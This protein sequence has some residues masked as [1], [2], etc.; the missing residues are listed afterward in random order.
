MTESNNKFEKFDE[1]YKI[2]PVPECPTCK[3]EENVIHCVY[4][5]PTKELS[6]YATAGNIVLMGCCVP[7]PDGKRAK[8]KCKKCDYIFYETD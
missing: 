8:A 6:E 1:L 2:N 3:T 7:T 4:G 5:R